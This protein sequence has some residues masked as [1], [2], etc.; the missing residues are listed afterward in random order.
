M[1]R[2]C[3]VVRLEELAATEPTVTYVE[4]MRFDTART[5]P[6]F[7]FA[8]EAESALRSIHITR[9]RTRLGEELP[10]MGPDERAGHVAE[11]TWTGTDAERFAGREALDTLG[12][13]GVRASLPYARSADAAAQRHMASYFGERYAET[14]DAACLDGLLAL[15][16]SEDRNVWGPA[17]GELGKTGAREVSPQLIAR[18]RRDGV[19]KSGPDVSIINVIGTLGDPG[20]I[21][22]LRE[23]LRH[24][25]RKV[26][27]TSARALG[28]M[29]QPGVDALIEA[30]SEEDPRVR[31]VAARQLSQVGGPDAA[32]A[33]DRYLDLHPDERDAVWIREQRTGE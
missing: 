32:E 26:A 15:V 21:P 5:A 27:V 6:R 17:L 24:G 2:R 11:L 23:E 25:S 4:T 19:T 30:S 22:F 13:E 3:L 8:T 31:G 14:R 18:A 16:D 7:P 10:R 28:R 20:A 12:A 33:V 29:G 1:A 9:A